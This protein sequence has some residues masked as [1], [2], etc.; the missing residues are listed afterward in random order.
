MRV[1]CDSSMSAAWSQAKDGDRSL[2]LDVELAER[3]ALEGRGDLLPNLLGGGDAARRAHADHARRD[4]DGVSPDVE[5]VAL[6]AD[7]A[8]DH[9][10]LNGL[11][12]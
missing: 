4:I 2:A 3:L 9:R 12:P 10:D 5:L 6:L 8:G 7:D 1:V 11:R